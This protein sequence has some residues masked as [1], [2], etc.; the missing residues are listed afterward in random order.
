MLE[1][2]ERR[3]YRRDGKGDGRTEVQERQTLGGVGLRHVQLVFYTDY[4]RML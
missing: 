2:E 1:S 3:Y 4:V